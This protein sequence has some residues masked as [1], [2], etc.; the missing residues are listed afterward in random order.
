MRNFVPNMVSF[1]ITSGQK[2]WYGVGSYVLP[3]ELPMINRIRQALECGPKGVGKLLVRNFK[4]FLENPRDQQEHLLATII[5]VHVLMDQAQ[6]F[7]P[8]RGK[9]EGR[10]DLSRGGWNTS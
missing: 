2:F 5:T 9:C 4:A 3:N 8:K 1:I 7:S 6:H 10:G